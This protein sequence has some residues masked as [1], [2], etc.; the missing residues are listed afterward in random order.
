M[1]CT[2]REMVAIPPLLGLHTGPPTF[3]NLMS[4]NLL[5]NQQGGKVS[6]SDGFTV[7]QLFPSDKF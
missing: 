4:Q 3:H 2:S 7:P 1:R 6:D 5:L